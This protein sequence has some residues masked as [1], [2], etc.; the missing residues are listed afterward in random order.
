MFSKNISVHIE[1]LKLA[2]R[3]TV[4]MKLIEDGCSLEGMNVQDCIDTLASVNY[5]GAYEGSIT[6]MPSEISVPSDIALYLIGDSMKDKV[7][8]VMNERSK[9]AAMSVPPEQAQWAGVA[10]IL[11]TYRDNTDEYQN[12]YRQVREL[13][14]QYS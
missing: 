9:R 7:N 10:Y 14:K 6:F 12:A 1:D 5:V 2:D 3:V 4:F 13:E 8:K 11:A